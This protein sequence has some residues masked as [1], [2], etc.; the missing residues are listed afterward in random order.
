[1]GRLVLER[2]SGSL[3]LAEG[4]CGARVLHADPARE[5]LLVA[6]TAAPGRSPVRLLGPRLRLDLG[7]SVEP[8]SVDRAP[9]ATP[10]LVALQP[11]ADDVLVDLERQELVRLEPSST[12]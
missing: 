2:A 12:V 11:G 5:R 6:C 3:V 4:R 7:V 8:R 9:E 1:D 10:R